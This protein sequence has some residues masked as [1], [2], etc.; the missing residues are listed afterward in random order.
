MPYK[1]PEKKKA[2]DRAYHKQLTPEQAQRKKEITESWWQTLPGKYHAQ[3]YHAKNRGILWN[4]SYE[5]W[6]DLWTKSGQLE[7][8]SADGYVMCRNG[9]E[10]PYELG[11]VYIAH[12]S[13]NK[14]DAWFNNKVALPNTGQYY[15]DL[16]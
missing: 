1:D 13:V 5:E 7:N 9:D 3:K 15:K 4:I 10:G 14:Q 16:L 8:R 6:L 12:N 2:Y 11:N